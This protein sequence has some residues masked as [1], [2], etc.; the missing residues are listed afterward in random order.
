[1]TSTTP[2]LTTNDSAVLQAL[3][4]AES[5]PSGPTINPS[6]PPFPA[7]LNITPEDHEALQSHQ[8]TILHPLQSPNPDPETIQTAIKALDTL[9]AENPTYPPTYVNRA[10]AFRILV[11]ASA[12]EI[13]QSTE[14]LTAIFSDLGEAIRLATPPSPADA[15]SP[16]QARVL[17][18]AHTHQG[19]LLLRLAKVKRNG[20]LGPEKWR[21]ADADRLEEM[22]SRDFFFGGRFGNRVAQQLAVQTNP[23]AKM[24]A[25]IVRGALRKEAEGQFI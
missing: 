8:I 14:A 25:A 9:I 3:F 10:Q 20:G 16:V 21:W 6:L 13:E 5:S 19:Y 2:I 23:Y 1:M 11:D 17:A 7:H 22:A 15:V 18:G 4:D 12:E 24:C